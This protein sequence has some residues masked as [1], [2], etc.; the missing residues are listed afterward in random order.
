MTTIKL[1]TDKSTAV[2]QTTFWTEITPTCKPVLGAKY[3]LIHKGAGVA[4][5]S[6][7]QADGWYT[8]FAGLPRF[9]K[10]GETPVT[11]AAL[12]DE[13]QHLRRKLAEAEHAYRS[14]Q[15]EYEHGSWNE[16]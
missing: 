13:M 9:L 11:V 10:P 7:F 6:T 12:Q 8:H 3:L 1:T 14:L 15:L 5:V 2:E 16:K 4:Q